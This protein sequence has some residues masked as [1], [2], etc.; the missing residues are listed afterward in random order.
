MLV[1]IQLEY[2]IKNKYTWTY[3]VSSQ[4]LKKKKI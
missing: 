2:M 3:T 1:A 4:Y